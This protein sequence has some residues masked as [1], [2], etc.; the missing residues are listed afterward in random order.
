MEEIICAGIEYYERPSATETVEQGQFD[1]S[2][3]IFER[4]YYHKS[5]GLT[6][7]WQD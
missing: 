5:Y 7:G 6:A 4:N 2:V 3:S 1:G